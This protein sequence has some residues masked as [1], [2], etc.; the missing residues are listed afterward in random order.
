MYP[1]D[2]P[3]PIEL[4]VLSCIL[5]TTHSR[6]HSRIEM[7]DFNK[8]ESYPAVVR[9]SFLLALLFMGR[10]ISYQL[11]SGVREREREPFTAH[12]KNSKAEDFAVLIGRS[13]AGTSPN[14]VLFMRA[15][16]V[17]LRAAAPSALLKS[18]G[19]LFIGFSR[20]RAWPSLGWRGTS[21]QVFWHSKQYVPREFLWT[22]SIEVVAAMP[23]LPCSVRSPRGKDLMHS[24]TQVPHTHLP[25]IFASMSC[26]IQ[27]RG[28]G[29]WVKLCVC[30][31]ALRIGVYVKPSPTAPLNI[32]GNSP[33]EQSQKA[34]WKLGWQWPWEIS[35]AKLLGCGGQFQRLDTLLE[36]GPCPLLPVAAMGFSLFIPSTLTCSSTAWANW[37]KHLCLRPLKDV[38]IG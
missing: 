35:G 17:Y 32:K 29:M 19:A 2:R 21:V 1:T 10:H 9:E 31:H 34:S 28:L 18:Q 20:Q 11:A 14:D 13:Q 22:C 4:T 15:I 8:W 23:L 26:S 5:E 3:Y 6:I 7:P 24:N 25:R 12:T 37:S 30:L 38:A 27:V 33:S 16:W 36:H